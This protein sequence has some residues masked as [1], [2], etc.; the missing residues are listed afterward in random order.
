MEDTC[1]VAVCALYAAAVS[2]AFA[3]DAEPAA[4]VALDADAVSDNFAA[5]AEDAA[6]SALA[7]AAAASPD[8][9]SADF[10]AADADWVAESALA[11]AAVSLALAAVALL[12]ASVTACSRSP[13]RSMTPCGR[14]WSGRRHVVSST[15]G[16]MPR[17]LPVEMSAMCYSS[18]SRLMYTP[19]LS[20]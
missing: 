10:A 11:L 6:P 17:C 5:L 18:V 4:A 12:L 1:S 20:L 13:W 8:A 14:Y 3:A 7:L 15:K 2:L 16:T 19:V 9:D